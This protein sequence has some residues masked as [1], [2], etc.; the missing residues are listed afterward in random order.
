VVGQVSRDD[1]IGGT[2]KAAPYTGKLQSDGT[3]K[4]A[5]YTTAYVGHRFSGAGGTWTAVVSFVPFVS[6]MF[7]LNVSAA[8]RA[9][10]SSTRSPTCP[11]T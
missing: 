5:A 3:A 7:Y 4:A 1:G 8:P 10:K 2:A 6:F 11:V 9:L